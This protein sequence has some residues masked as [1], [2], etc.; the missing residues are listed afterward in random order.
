MNRQD[1]EISGGVNRA[2][3][4]LEIIGYSSYVP[5]IEGIH[6]PM[7]GSPPFILRRVQYYSLEL[8]GTR[9]SGPFVCHDLVGDRTWIC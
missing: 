5:Y 4:F 2:V 9:C 3:E 1:R 8:F 7:V 6:D